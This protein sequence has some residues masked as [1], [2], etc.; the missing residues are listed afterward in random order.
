MIITLCGSAR[1]E[2]LFHEWNEALTMTGHTVFSLAVFPSTKGGHKGWYTMREKII[3]DKVH[4]DKISASNAIVVLNHDGYIGDSTRSEIEFAAGLNKQLFS[5]EPMPENDCPIDGILKASWG[6]ARRLISLDYKWPTTSVDNPQL[7]DVFEDEEILMKAFGNTVGIFNA[8]QLA[9]YAAL[10]LEETCEFLCAVNPMQDGHF[11]RFFEQLTYYLKRPD[12]GYID[13]QHMDPV[14]VFDALQ[15][16]LVVTINAGHSA[17]FPMRDG[18]AEVLKANM[19]KVD[20]VTG[21]VRR[22][23]GSDGLP[24]G[25]VLKPQGWIA[26]DARLA[27]LLDKKR[28]AA[29]QEA[30]PLS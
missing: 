12:V 16:M 2:N 8:E 3:L 15:D 26:P 6:L 9:L 13:P 28:G 17:G 25:K 22:S 4:K 5:I 20:P 14:K 10:I 30:T 23:D 19:E 21:L 11:K 29:T 18:W 1:F 27:L 7:T 24:V